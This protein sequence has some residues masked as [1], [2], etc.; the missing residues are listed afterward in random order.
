[1]DA[2][3]HGPLVV[4]GDVGGQRER[5]VAL[6]LNR[7]RRGG[8][9]DV[10]GARVFRGEN[11]RNRNA[12]MGE[13]LRDVL[14]RRAGV[15]ASVRQ[16]ED[17]ADGDAEFVHPED[18]GQGAAEIRVARKGLDGEREGRRNGS[19]R[20]KI[21][22]RFRKIL[23]IIINILIIHNS[24]NLRQA[25]QALIILREHASGGVDEG[26]EFEILRAGNLDDTRRIGDDGRQNQTGD[27]SGGHDQQRGFGL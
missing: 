23:Q 15:G 21:G 10:Q 4:G 17:G 26:D 16:E 11:G 9:G 1:M 2:D 12:R 27:D 24:C 19:V 14:R 3:V 5:L 22:L 18:M 20:K 7:L 8:D 25:R 13:A 6:R